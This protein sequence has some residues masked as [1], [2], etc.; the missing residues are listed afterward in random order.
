MLRWIGHLEYQLGDANLAA[1]AHFLK[2]RTAALAA[3]AGLAG[4]LLPWALPS[5]SGSLRRSSAAFVLVLW[6]V[7]MAVFFACTGEYPLHFMRH[8]AYFFLPAAL[9][10]AFASGQAAGLAGRRRWFIVPVCALFL[11]YAALNYRQARALD[12]ELRTNDLEWQVL[13]EAARGLPRG[14]A[15]VYPDF[16]DSRHALLGKYFRLAESGEA[17]AGTCFVKYLSPLYQIAPA[18]LPKTAQ[19]YNPWAPGYVQA[20]EEPLFGRVFPHRSYCTWAEPRAPR[21]IKTGFYPAA[22]P[23]DRAWLLALKAGAGPAGGSAEAQKLLGE[24]AGLDPDCDLCRYGL[25]MRLALGGAAT[26]AAVQLDYIV[27]AGMLRDKAPLACAIGDIA[28]GNRAA[29]REEIDEF[30]GTGLGRGPFDAMALHA[31]EALAAGEKGQVRP[32]R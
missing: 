14:C 27:K 10:F 1:A 23:R 7:Y 18:D 31:R 30:L 28:L 6:L 12:G 3:A 20:R 4:I 17:L 32:Q 26:D 11:A 19:N 5:G 2:G 8:Q 21:F 22:T 24:G 9:L 25:A 16:N 29:A 13:L 15:V